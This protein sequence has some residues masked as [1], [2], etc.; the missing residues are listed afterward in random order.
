MDGLSR[1]SLFFCRS[2]QW[3]V[4]RYR[5]GGKKIILIVRFVIGNNLI[6]KREMKYLGNIFFNMVIYL[7]NEE[8]FDLKIKILIFCNFEC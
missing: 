3:F 5:I 2:F 1:D 8:V 4:N 7:I 6:F